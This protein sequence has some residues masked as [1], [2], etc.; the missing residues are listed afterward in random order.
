MCTV[1]AIIRR[2]VLEES[3]GDVPVDQPLKALTRDLVTLPSPVTCF[4]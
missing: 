4:I 3:K 1:T 2:V